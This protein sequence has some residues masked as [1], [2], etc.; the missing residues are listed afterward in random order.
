[1]RVTRRTLLAAAVAATA[2][3]TGIRSNTADTET[4]NQ[5]ATPDEPTEMSPESGTDGERAFVHWSRELPH[6]ELGMLSLGGGPVTPA[7]FVGSAASD[8]ASSEDNH[9]LHAL[10]LQEGREMWRAGVPNPVQTAPRYVGT[11][12]APRVVFATGRESLH[13]EGSEIRAVDHSSGEHVWR[14][15]IDD[16][17]FLYPIVTNEE[18]VFVGRRD[19]QFAESGEYVYAL[20]GSDG[21]ERWRAETGDVSRSGNARRRDNLLVKTPG[22]VSALDMESGDERWRVEADT[23]GYDNRGKRVFVQTGNTVRA[24]ALADG[25]QRWRREFDFDVSTVT[26]PREAMDDT[27]FVGDSDGRLLAS[28]P[29]DGETRWTLSVDGDGFRPSVERTSEL[30]YVGGAGVHAVEPVSGERQWSFTPDVEERVDV[31]AST[32]V[33]ASTDRRLWALNP[34]SGE[35]RWEFAPGGQFAGM[36][37]AGESAFVAVDGTAYALD[38]SESS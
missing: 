12:E 3:C 21:D 19:D 24:L 35:V 34:K 36:A 11:E 14:F 9:A 28:S 18:T 6:D 27:V 37:S 2:G 7:I 33:F 10:T 17:R 22:R 38:G 20:D 1:M 4:E 30:L 31:D 23:V 25:S 8:D 15:D 26:T 5:T 16:R 32:A 13:G 29:L